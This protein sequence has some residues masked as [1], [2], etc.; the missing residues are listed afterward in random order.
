MKASIA[1]ERL[2][3]A[4]MHKANMEWMQAE[5][6]KSHEMMQM[7]INK[8]GIEPITQ[9]PPATQSP[10]LRLEGQLSSSNMSKASIPLQSANV[11][12]PLPT[13]EVVPIPLPPHESGQIAIDEENACVELMDIGSEPIK[14]KH[15]LA[16]DASK[17]GL[18]NTSQPTDD[19]SS[20]CAL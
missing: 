15:N 7:L 4:Q 20:C 8:I 1:D 5:S 6:N 3:N 9:L 11:H 18:G 13:E 2:A 14:V 17:A 12:P 19:P 16:V 10:P